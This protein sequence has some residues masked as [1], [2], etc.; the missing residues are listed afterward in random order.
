MHSYITIIFNVLFVFTVKYQECPEIL[1]PSL[2]SIIF[3]T[4]VECIVLEITL[5]YKTI[6]K[7]RKCEVML[8]CV[9]SF[10]IPKVTKL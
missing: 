3:E 9:C 10:G 7:H 6:N 8:T 1:R 2:P 5:D 4:T